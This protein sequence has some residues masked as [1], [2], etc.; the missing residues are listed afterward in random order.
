MD[1]QI[2]GLSEEP[3]STEQIRAEL[4]AMLEA[5][6]DPWE[7][8]RQW[9]K[10][11]TDKIDVWAGFPVP[12]DDAQL[13]IHPKYPG[14]EIL[15]GKDKPEE[16]HELDDWVMRNSWV[17][18]RDHV[19]VFAAQ[20]P[21]GKVVAR[22]LGN[23]SQRM[24]MELETQMAS[25]VW[26][27]EA[28]TKALEYLRELTTEDQFRRYILTGGFG[29][30]SERSGVNYVLRRLRPTIALKKQPDDTVKMLAALCMH[31]I[32]YYQ[33]SWA[34]SMVPTD[35]VIAHLAF[36]RGDEHGYWKRCNQHSPLSL[37]AGL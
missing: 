24:N 30:R 9:M 32:G 5:S 16:P 4:D 34:G 25:I 3:K 15:M 22:Y 29:E 31:P 1:G 8:M 18:H 20:R 37:E 6:D 14:A 17:N 36:I 27:I 2:D 7:R 21:D 19:T 10:R 35:D 33:G 11:L 13:V 23:K 26:S 12:V 28:E